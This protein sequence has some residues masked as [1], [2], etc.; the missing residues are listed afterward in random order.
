VTGPDLKADSNA[1]G[2]EEITI[3]HEGI[4]RVK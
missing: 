3:V 4:V 2:V 1:Y